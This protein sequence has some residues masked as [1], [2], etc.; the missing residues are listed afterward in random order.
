VSLAAVVA[1]SGAM[2]G[3]VFLDADAQGRGALAWSGWRG[4]RYVARVYDVTSR[5][6]HHLQGV[7]G[8][9][10]SL[11]LEDFD[12]AA[13]GAAVACV[14][15]RPA[16]DAPW[17]VRVFR[18]GPQGAWSRG[19]TVAASKRYVEHL[20]CGAGDAGQ[21]SLAWD[22]G[23]KALRAAHVT[24]DGTVEPAATLAPEPIG[25]PALEVAADGTTTVSFEREQV[26]EERTTHVAQRPVAGGWTTRLVGPGGAH[27][28]ALDGTGR[29]LLAWT[30]WGDLGASRTLELATGP[31]FTAGVLVREP[32]ISVS[33]LAGSA[34]GDVLVAW[35][36][37]QWQRS[38]WLRVSVQRPGGPFS[39]P[40]VLG[41][42]AYSGV[43]ATLGPDGTGALLYGT[44]RV[45]RP[46]G[47]LQFLRPDGTWTSRRP[48][49]DILALA[50]AAAGRFTAAT[51][52]Y[53]RTRGG[54]NRFVLGTRSVAGP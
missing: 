41:R 46:R 27:T 53:Q 1:T 9:R 45:D 43:R 26:D 8:L 2:F 33:A 31:D 21:A 40:L 11:A 16:R 6:T 51:V 3:G 37:S 35:S 19:I 10:G 49:R 44:G 54:G 24:A 30:T 25:S 17:R 42:D 7:H 22:E 20:V 28:L 4:D 15:H 38:G 52:R 48:A 12:V 23:G 36:V 14:L 47:V 29:P 18:R 50:P 34:R 5:R 39:P 32:E 13:S